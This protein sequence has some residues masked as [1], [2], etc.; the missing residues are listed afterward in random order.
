MSQIVSHLIVDQAL[1]TKYTALQDNLRSLRSVVVAFSGGVD[2]SLLA[3]VAH[4]VL[5]PH[6]LAVTIRSEVETEGI[7]ST[8]QSLAA[9]FSFPH[10]IIDYNKL[11]DDDYVKNSPDRCYVCKTVDLGII[12]QIAEKAGIEH[13]LMGANADD[14]GDYRP[15]LRAAKELHVSSPLAEVGFNK[16][17]IR[18]LARELGLGNWNHPSSPCLASR[19]PYGSKVTREKLAQVAA[20]EAYLRALNFPIVRVRNNDLLARIEVPVEDIARLVSL[21]EEIAGYFKQIGFRYITVDLEGF[22]S[23]SLN[24]VLKSR[25]TAK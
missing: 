13:V 7:M 3:V 10:Q 24:E 17:E 19:I 1:E 4:Q 12:T 15:G 22:R 5:A 11:Q 23:G 8:A 16:K 14:L 2:S 21:S 6:M 25:T 18:T 9:Q 20:G